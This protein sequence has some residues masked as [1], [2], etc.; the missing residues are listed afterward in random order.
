MGT[1]SR[2]LAVKPAGLSFS[3]NVWHFRHVSTR[4]HNQTAARCGLHVEYAFATNGERI[5]RNLLSE[6]SHSSGCQQKL[7][8]SDVYITLTR[9]SRNGIVEEERHLPRGCDWNLCRSDPVKEDDVFKKWGRPD[10]SAQ[11]SERD[12]W[13]KYM[14]FPC[15]PPQEIPVLLLTQLNAIDS[16]RKSIIQIVARCTC[17]FSP[18][19]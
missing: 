6:K 4:F 3:G 9:H 11:P 16:W 14:S 12:S 8:R 2:V 19:K 17:I 18:N 7:A 13:L 15:N 10:T 5:N 1:E